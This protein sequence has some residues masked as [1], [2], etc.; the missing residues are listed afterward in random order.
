[1]LSLGNLSCQ[2]TVYYLQM[3][4]C[5]S[6][7]MIILQISLDGVKQAVTVL[8]SLFVCR[9]LQSGLRALASL[10]CGSMT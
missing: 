3:F 8:V 4:D 2:S 1:M 10:Q 6:S 9:H 5:S 7:V